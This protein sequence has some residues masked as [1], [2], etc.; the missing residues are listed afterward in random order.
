MKKLNNK[1]FA[2]STLI[3]GLAIMGIMIVAILMATMAQTR[4]NNNSLAKSIEEDLNRFSKTETSF[5]PIGSG[6]SAQEYIVPESGWYKIELWGAQGGGDGGKGAYTGGVIE[7]D[8]GEV[9]YFY[10]GKHKSSGKGYASDVRIVDGDY[11]EKSSYETRIM[12]AAG[13]GSGSKAAGGTLYG[14][15][16]HMVS[17]GGFIKSQGSD[18][19]YSL[20]PTDAE[21]NNTN[22]TLVGYPSSYAVSTATNPQIGVDVP[23]PR[24]SDDGGDGFFPS[25]N[26]GTGGTSYIAGYAGCFGVKKGKT[27]QNSKLEYYE[28]SYEED[29]GQES[30]DPYADTSSGIYYFVDGVMMPGVHTGDGYATIERVKPKSEAGTVLARRN[31]KLNGVRYIKDCTGDA[32]NL[33]K[34]L[35]S[36][37]GNTYTGEITSITDKC[38]MVDIGSNVNADE[39]AVFHND[40]GVDYKNDV[41]SVSSD[42]SN[43]IDIKGS[44][45][46]LSETETVT[47]YRVSAYQYDSTTALPSKGNYIIQPVLSENKVLTAAPTAET[48]ANPI[49]IEPYNGEK[50]Q[51]WSIELITDTRINP[52][53]DPNN[54]ETYEYKIVE[55]ARFKALSITQDENLEFN[56]LSAIDKFNEY[57][58]NEPQIW[59]IKPVGNGTYTIS[60][61]VPSQNNNT[62]YTLPQTNSTVSDAL[63]QIIIGKNT[64]Q[65]ARY[66]LIQID[67]SSN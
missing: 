19:D 36:A 17:R 46:E 63:N 40:T 31:T 13:G 42:N 6:I 27:T 29:D 2:I 47:G 24:S 18:R 53:Y 23:N 58:R 12:V 14:Y 11:A 1:G 34:I 62:G 35:V 59:K 61:V 60:T 54:I 4:S 48:N 64:I 16:S 45:S 10:V 21:G 37:S 8:E 55:L 5:K 67:Y 39:I 56:T 66:K 57:A 30:G 22:G 44:G 43:W 28:Y 52:S 15:N 9:L 25:N 26:S 20:L 65:T 7:L 33:N 3:Y 38:K 41:I 50:R 49:T 32:N 51:K